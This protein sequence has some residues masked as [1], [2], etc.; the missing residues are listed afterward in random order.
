MKREKRILTILIASLLCISVLS[1]CNRAN[2]DTP[3]TDNESKSMTSSATSEYAG[4]ETSEIIDNSTGEIIK[5]ES[6]ISGTRGE[7]SGT[8]GESSNSDTPPSSS[9]IPAGSNGGSTT[10]PTTPPTGNNSRP[11]TPP[12]DNL[13]P[14][15]IPDHTHK[16]EYYITLTEPL[17]DRDGVDIEKCAVCGITRDVPN[18]KRI[19]HAFTFGWEITKQPTLTETGIQER[20]CSRCG[21][22]ETGTVPKVV[23]KHQPTKLEYEMLEYINASRKEAG[24]APLVFNYM[25]YDC[26][27]IRGQE[28]KEFYSHTRPN[29]KDWLTVLFD[30][31]FSHPKF[32][33][34]N[35]QSGANFDG[36]WANYLFMQSPG[37]K[38]NM[39]NKDYT[40]VSLRI[41]I[42]ETPDEFGQHHY[43]FVENFYG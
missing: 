9:T 22:H 26:A 19:P 38:A 28:I 35:I 16:W 43:Y 20:T 30:N 1:G 41:Y 27:Y 17:C 6:E 10:E 40:S 24:V 3:L 8:Q 23:L 14:E 13:P 5:N 15:S 31:G 18:T 29:G 2:N 4:K 42:D 36:Y 39:L 7:T 33:G 11:T 25:Y 12:N 21:F 34:E 37:H 32:A